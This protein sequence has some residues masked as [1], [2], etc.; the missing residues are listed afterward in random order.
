MRLVSFFIINSIFLL[1]PGCCPYYIDWAKDLL[2]A[3]PKINL[4]IEQVHAQATRTLKIR[5]DELIHIGLMTKEIIH[6]LW[7]NN[8]V[9]T[10]HTQLKEYCGDYHEKRS[11]A[12]QTT[13]TFLVSLYEDSRD[14]MWSCSLKK[15]G[16]TYQAKEVKPIELDPHY[17]TI[18]G[19]TAYRYKQHIYSVSF[20][21]NLTTP[22]ELVFCN[23]IYQ[24]AIEWA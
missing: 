18:F 7:I 13:A 23:G 20:D 4:P 24:D 19:K 14:G 22:F 3:T 10:L 6:V 5:D 1:L 12:N 16:V 9:I 2:H 21:I 8:D 11:S 17:K 15:D